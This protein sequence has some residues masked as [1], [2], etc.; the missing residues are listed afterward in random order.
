MST[1]VWYGPRGSNRLATYL[2]YPLLVSQHHREFRL[3]RDLSDL[4]RL[5]R[6]SKLHATVLLGN[7]SDLLRTGH[8]TLKD[9]DQIRQEY[10]RVAFFDA[11][12]NPLKID[13]EVL[14]RVDV[15]FKSAVYNDLGVYS[16]PIVGGTYWLDWFHYNVQSSELPAVSTGLEEQELVKLRLAWNI[17]YGLYPRS[18]V[19]KRLPPHLERWLGPRMATK[20]R[21]RVPKF[22][23]NPKRHPGIHARM[24]LA[25]QGEALRVHRE[26]FIKSA[27]RISTALIGI[28]GRRQYQ[29]ELRS[30]TT[31][32]SP[33]GL[34]E[35]CYRDFEAVQCGA[36]LL[37]PSMAHLKTWPDVYSQ[38]ASIPLAW[39]G[40]DIAEAYERTLNPE[41]SRCLSESAY[42]IFSDAYRHLDASVESFIAAVYGI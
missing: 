2:L 1:A 42:E 4:L 13:K 18:S 12:P 15:Y 20:L 39:D 29:R 33:F 40:S 28:A 14:E 17:G 32:L 19:T 38:S 35:P 24:N 16:K 8:L 21:P 27:S 7:A 31:V 23:G 41:F 26:H 11:T 6:E 34:G 10:A 37:K 30:V 9:L 36:V 5:G 3:A 22:L 25:G